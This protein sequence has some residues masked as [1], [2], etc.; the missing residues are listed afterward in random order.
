VRRITC[1]VGKLWFKTGTSKRRNYLQTPTAVCGVRGTTIEGGY[2]NTVSLL[3]VIA[4]L[5]DKVGPWEEGPFS[6]PGRLKAL[7]NRVFQAVE[8][9]LSLMEKAKATGDPVDLARAEMAA[10]GVVIAAA[11][12]LATNPDET[13]RDEAGEAADAARELIAEIQKS[14]PGAVPPRPVPPKRPPPQPPLKV[15]LPDT[16]TTEQEEYQEEAS[17]SQ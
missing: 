1:F 5:V 7:E 6:N 9:A 2:D 15:P 16:E 4:G 17:P 14:I 11:E 8:Q 3:N 13:I 12:L 10:L